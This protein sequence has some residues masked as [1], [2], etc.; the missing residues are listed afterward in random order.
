MSIL[1][2]QKMRYGR[3][4][5]YISG[6]VENPKQFASMH[7]VQRHMIDTKLCRMAYDD[8]E[9]EYADFYDFSTQDQDPEGMCFPSSTSCPHLCSCESS[10][11]SH[12]LC[13]CR[14]CCAMM[15]QTLPLT[16][17]PSPGLHAEDLHM[18]A[19]DAEPA[20]ASSSG[21]EI[22]VPG[23]SEGSVKLLGSRQFARFYRQRHRPSDDRAGIVANVSAA[24]CA[25]SSIARGFVNAYAVVYP[26]ML[27]CWDTNLLWLASSVGMA[28][29]VN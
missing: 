5:L 24:K 25:P 12:V 18:V 3:M 17:Q 27:P 4:P 23:E 22:A 19:A 28:I 20:D 7:A 10:A 16:I 29:V 15:A 14:G 8:N 21:Y 2:A 13:C 1:Q 26:C 6:E 9:E 11:C